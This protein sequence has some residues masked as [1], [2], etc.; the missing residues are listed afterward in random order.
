MIAKLKFIGTIQTGDKINVKLMT[1]QNDC[2]L[3][4]LNRT[5]F[6]IDDRGNTLIFITSIINKSFEL[7][8]SLEKEK[9]DN[10]FRMAL[11][12]NLISDIKKSIEGIK[13]LEETYDSDKLFCCKLEVL[14]EEISAR[15]GKVEEHKD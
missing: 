1:I 8:T 9:G 5:I 10:F 14:R 13:N 12:T 7:L 11:Y 6:N 2:F 15:I 4:K 3:T